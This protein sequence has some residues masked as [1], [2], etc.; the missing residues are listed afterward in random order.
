M[1]PHSTG[2]FATQ[3]YRWVWK[4]NIQVY[5]GY[6]ITVYGHLNAIS[7]SGNSPICHW[8]L[9]RGLFRNRTYTMYPPRNLLLGVIS[10]RRATLPGLTPDLMQLWHRLVLRQGVHSGRTL[11]CCQRRVSWRHWVSCLPLQHGYKWL[12]ARSLCPASS[13]NPANNSPTY[14]LM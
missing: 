1:E 13:S 6:G 8:E 2:W 14:E 5:K 10:N 9:T 12:L 4:G 3:K 7:G 11:R